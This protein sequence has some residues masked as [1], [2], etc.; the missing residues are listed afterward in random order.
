MSGTWWSKVRNFFSATDEYRVNGSSVVDSATNVTDVQNN[1][2]DKRRGVAAAPRR[3]NNKI[4]IVLFNSAD[5]HDDAAMT[6]A[7]ADALH[8][9]KTVIVNVSQCEKGMRSRIVDFASGMVFMIDGAVNQIDTYMYMFSTGDCRFSVCKPHDD[10]LDISDYEYSDY[11]RAGY[12][13]GGRSR[14]D[15]V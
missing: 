14:G 13:S 8:D 5:Y 3:R 2:S 7:I 10:D 11:R 9:N 12:S 1:V 4:D 15:Y 6:N